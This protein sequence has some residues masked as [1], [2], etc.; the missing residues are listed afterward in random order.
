MNKSEVQKNNHEISVCK[1]FLNIYN[2]KIKFLK[3]GNPHKFEADCICSDNFFIEI[4]GIYDSEKQAKKIWGNNMETK[5]KEDYKFNLFSF[6]NLNKKILEKTQKL[7][8][9]LYDGSNGKI[10]L[11]C[12]MLSP[13]VTKKDV[14]LVLK[15]YLPFKKDN[16]FK[17]YFYE[18]WVLWKSENN[19]DYKIERLE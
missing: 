19:V 11:V 4:V 7:N 13:T 12:D 18:V 6:D 14:D 5:I 9:G 15:S 16:Y 2:K 17:R 1:N 3:H 10:I 8:N